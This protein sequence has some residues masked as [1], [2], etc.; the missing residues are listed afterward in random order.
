MPPDIDILAD[1][2]W[3]LEPG[4][5]VEVRDTGFDFGFGLGR[6]RSETRVPAADGGGFEGPRLGGGGVDVCTGGGGLLGPPLAC[7][8]VE[9]S[10]LPDI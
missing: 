4:P 2:P 3:F 1:E 7:T 6:P 8:G 5:G 10:D 9:V